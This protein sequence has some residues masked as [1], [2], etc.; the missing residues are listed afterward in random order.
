MCTGRF[1]VNLLFVPLCLKKR[2]FIVIWA[3]EQNPQD[4]DAGR[5]HQ[6][7]EERPILPRGVR[8]LPPEK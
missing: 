3:H 1:C 2:D 8:W 4:M 7:G 6:G 5:R